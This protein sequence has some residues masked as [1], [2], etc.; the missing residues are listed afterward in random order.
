MCSCSF[1]TTSSSLV[2]GTESFLGRL[3]ALSSKSCSETVSEYVL[4]TSDLL[5]FSLTSLS[6]PS[7]KDSIS[8]ASFSWVFT[9]LS[10]R[11]PVTDSISSSDN[12][13]CSFSSCSV[14]SMMSSCDVSGFN[15]FNWLASIFSS[16]FSCVFTST[17]WSETDG[18]MFPSG[19]VS[20][21]VSVATITT[22]SKATMLCSSFC[23]SAASFLHALKFVS[24]KTLVTDSTSSSDKTWRSFSS[25][26]VTSM[27]S[28]CNFSSFNSSN[29][30]ASIFSSRFSSVFTS[31]VWFETGD[32]M[33]PS[34]D[35]SVF[36]SVAT[37]TTSSVATI[38][39]SS[40]LSSGISTGKYAL[41]SITLLRF[42]TFSSLNVS[43]GSMSVLF[44][45]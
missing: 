43:L 24:P 30:L 7:D 19:E 37:T 4:L 42:S 31:A 20:V 1:N 40:S 38:F 44:S 34:G 6:L 22:S 16:R 33:F 27:L 29:W 32:P 8:V 35:V 14:K 41:I 21:F 26:S 12:T 25:C 10:P 2:S 9:F 5:C 11:T 39:C 28:S 36:V 23:C 18:P 13:W 17:V 3:S 15:S 45:S